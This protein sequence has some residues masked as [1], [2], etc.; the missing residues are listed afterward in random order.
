MSA[1]FAAAG[2][3]V[4]SGSLIS[5]SG[6]WLRAFDLGVF[7][8]LP[9]TLRMQRLVLREQERYGEKLQE[10]ARKANFEAFMEWARQ[11]DDPGFSGRNIAQHRQWLAGMTGEKMELSSERSVEENV[12]A[13]LQIIQQMQG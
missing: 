7:L 12:H 4:V 10:P 11:Y 2:D 13:L 5:W 6:N 8:T 9:H 3:V 1:A